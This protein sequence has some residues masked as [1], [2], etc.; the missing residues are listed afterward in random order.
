MYP[1]KAFFNFGGI[2]SVKSCA[3]KHATTET[4]RPLLKYCDYFRCDTVKKIFTR[5]AGERV[6]RFS[7]SVLGNLAIC[8]T[9]EILGGAVASWALGEIFGKIAQP[10][11]ELAGSH[12]N[13]LAAGALAYT[14]WSWST[15]VIEVPCEED[16]D[17]YQFVGEGSSTSSYIVEAY[18]INALQKSV[19]F[20]LSLMFCF[21]KLDCSEKGSEFGLAAGGWTGE[22]IGMILGGYLGLKIAGADLAFL[23]EDRINSYV[24]SMIRFLAAGIGYDIFLGYKLPVPILGLP[25]TC[26]RALIQTAAYNYPQVELYARKCIEEKTVS[27]MSFF[28]FLAEMIANVGRGS[29]SNALVKNTAVSIAT[30]IPFLHSLFKKQLETLIRLGVQLGFTTISDNNEEI[31][32]IIIRSLH[33]YILLV[34]TNIPIQRALK[35]PEQLKIVLHKEVG[36][37]LKDKSILFRGVIEALVNDEGVKE[38]LEPMR[39]KI[40]QLE[41]EIFSFSIFQEKGSLYLKD[42]AAVHLHYYTIFAFL[43]WREFTE[44]VLPIEEE[45]MSLDF[46]AV[47]CQSYLRYALWPNVTK[48]MQKISGLALHSLFKMKKIAASYWRKPEAVTRMRPSD[49]GKRKAQYF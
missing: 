31:A 45:Q 26:L 28:P 22:Q 40:K 48:V 12:T 49:L 6:Q 38:A 5:C 46:N 33:A 43:Q 2:M 39:G 27:K 30:C 32:A 14:A 10:I 36:T 9:A 16:D 11:G 42:A 21:L 18:K 47:I 13:L 23:G 7:N 17:E 41:Q 1:A 4:R 37:V 35:D 15:N 25:R 24:I 34:K 20:S 44:P 19:L 8:S 29:H 3:C